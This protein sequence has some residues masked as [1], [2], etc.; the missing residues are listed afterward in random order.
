M[1]RL[2]LVIPVTRVPL[3]YIGGTEYRGDYEIYQLIS[4]M[5]RYLDPLVW[6][7]RNFGTNLGWTAIFFARRRD[8]AFSYSEALKFYCIYMYQKHF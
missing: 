6:A 2:D 3:S 1:V 8:T 7:T 5:I 4:K